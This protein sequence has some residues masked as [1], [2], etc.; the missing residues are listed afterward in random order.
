MDRFSERKEIAQKGK[1][2]TQAQCLGGLGSRWSRSVLPMY[3]F[4]GKRRPKPTDD[5]VFQP[6][7]HAIRTLGMVPAGCDRSE[8]QS[9]DP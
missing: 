1:L 7:A 6:V 2:L 8:I 4:Q 3:C 5:F 9:C